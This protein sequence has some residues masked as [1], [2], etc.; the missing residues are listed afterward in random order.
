MRPADRAQRGRQ[1][2]PTAAGKVPSRHVRVSPVGQA[3][4][5]RA[6]S[7][8]GFASRGR[9]GGT[10]GRRREAR[11]GTARPCRP[12]TARE[13]SRA[14]VGAALGAALLLEPLLARGRVS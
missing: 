2:M 14:G 13:G 6:R 9:F 12:R 7:S 8:S 5:C 4:S 11:S 10:L 3:R 1:Q